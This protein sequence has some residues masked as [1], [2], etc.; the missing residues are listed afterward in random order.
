[1][2]LPPSR[3]TK[4]TLWS[5]RKTDPRTCVQLISPIFLQPHGLQ[6]TRLPCP[7]LSPRVCSNS[8]PLSQWWHPTISFSVIPFSSCPQSPSIRVFSNELALFISCGQS[9]GAS[10]SASVILIN[11]QGWFPLGW[12][13][14]ISLQSKGLLETITYSHSCWCLVSSRWNIKDVYYTRVVVNAYYSVVT[15]IRD[16]NSRAAESGE[17]GWI[18]KPLRLASEVQDQSTYIRSIRPLGPTASSTGLPHTHHGCLEPGSPGSFSTFA[19]VQVPHLAGWLFAV[20]AKNLGS[21]LTHLCPQPSPLGRVSLYP[22]APSSLPSPAWASC[23]LHGRLPSSLHSAH[24]VSLSH[25]N[26]KYSETVHKH[27]RKNR[28]MYTI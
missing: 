5:S 3:V 8:Y 25:W 16:S 13:G 28:N 15:V 14:W 17:W 21:S 2:S 6:H 11:V 10:A 18:Q 1:M 24:S 4:T 19:S 27:Q 7:S 22:L 20:T 12:T 9:I 26:C 23:V